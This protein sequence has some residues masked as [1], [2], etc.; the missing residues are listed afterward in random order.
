MLKYKKYIGNRFPL[1]VELY[2][3][4]QSSINNVLNF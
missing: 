4:F 1:L 2:F 3:F